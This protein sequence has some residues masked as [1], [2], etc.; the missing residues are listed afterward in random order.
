MADDLAALRG[1]RVTV[2]I[3]GSIAAYKAVLLVRLLTKAGASVRVVMTASAR[4]FVGEST[5]S[6]L[7]ASPVATDMFDPT[8]GGEAH[9]ELAQSS[10][11]IVVAPATADFLARLAAGR[12][13]DL[14]AA[15]VLCA[16][17]PVLVAPAMHPTMWAH[18]ATARNVAALSKDG[19]QILGPAEGEVASGNV[20]VG[21]LLEPDDIARR[22]ASRLGGGDLAG[23]RL[24]VTAGPTVEDLDPVRFIG[25]RSS[26]KMGF[27]LA[28]RAARRGA[29]VTL[30]AGPVALATPPGVKRIDVRS[31]LD[32]KRELFAVLGPDLE[33]ADAL[34]MCAAVGDYRAERVAKEKLK[35][36][37]DGLTLRLVQN[38]DVLSEVGAARRGKRPVLVGFAVET[39]TDARIVERARAKLR[40][41]RV[42]VVVANHA[43]ESMG[44]DDNRVL[45]VDDD[46][47]DALPA[48]PKSDVADRIVDWLAKRLANTGPARA[49]KRRKR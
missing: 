23:V 22:V 12:A 19:V 38:P 1:R 47:A 29:Q 11:L 44:R 49:A 46:S 21:R 43:A 8:C 6:G 3:T 30:V 20:G 15:T 25:N 7:T 35:R 33:K 16:R 37:D 45:I 39:G 36:G 27:A 26:G 32:L 40:K 14:L 28:E 41:K 34:L 4:A 9:V 48:L 2:G 10:D 31:A 5:L 24:V 17:C 13:D 18:P 42:D